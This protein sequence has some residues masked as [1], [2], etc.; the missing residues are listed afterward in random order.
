MDT[1][2]TGKQTKRSSVLISFVIEDGLLHRK[3]VSPKV[4]ALKGELQLI[5]PK[6]FQNVV[7][8]QAHTTILA[9]HMGI[10]KTLNRI[11]SN[12]F[13]PQVSGDVTRYCKSCDICQRT[14][15]K[16]QTRKVP[17]GVM[18]IISIPFERVGVDIV[19]PLRPSNNNGNRF[20][21]TLI[22]VATRYPEAVAVCNIDTITIAE[23]LLGIFSRTGIPREILSDNGSQFTSH[24]MKEFH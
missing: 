14:T 20:I 15:P 5:V 7:L 22:D 13:W 24:M 11:I 16:G 18:P 2:Q 17:L 10:G 19:G 3:V 1:A 12:F 21:L 6:C 23:A 8:A 4:Q 9:G